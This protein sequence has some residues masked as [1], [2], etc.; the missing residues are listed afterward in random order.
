M[1]S[2]T[3]RAAFYAAMPRTGSISG[4]QGRDDMQ[5][6]ADIWIAVLPGEGVAAVYPQDDVSDSVIACE[7]YN[8]RTIAVSNI[9]FYLYILRPDRDSNAGPTA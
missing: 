4:D 1:Q 9:D 3:S 7:Q 6:A 2:F 8:I 5:T